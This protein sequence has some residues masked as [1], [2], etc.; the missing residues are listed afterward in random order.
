MTTAITSILTVTTSSNSTTIII[1]MTTMS[2]NIC[3]MTVSGTMLKMFCALSH[4][5]YIGIII[6]SVLLLSQLIME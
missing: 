4:L 2:P 6:T 5:I 3:Q 1:T